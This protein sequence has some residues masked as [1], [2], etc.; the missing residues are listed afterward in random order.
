MMM[1]SIPAEDGVEVPGVITAAD[2]GVGEMIVVA[3][4]AEDGVEVPGVIAAAADAGV[5]E[6]IV[7]AI[8]AG[9]GIEVP[10]VSSADAGGVGEMAMTG[11]SAGDVCEPSSSSPDPCREAG[12]SSVEAGLSGDEVSCIQHTRLINELRQGDC[13]SHPKVSDRLAT[14]SQLVA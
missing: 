1:V 3:I 13:N 5:G 11:M 6:M 2:A 10:G 7:V 8:S 4:P 14:E 9:D 12:T